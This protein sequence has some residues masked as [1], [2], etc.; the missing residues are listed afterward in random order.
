MMIYSSNITNKLITNRLNLVVLSDFTAEVFVWLKEQRKKRKT[1]S[2]TR[3][4]CYS[5]FD[6]LLPWKPGF[7]DLLSTEEEDSSGDDFN[8]SLSALRVI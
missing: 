3:A 6:A 4:G 1:P 8:V 5:R 7:Y 2:D